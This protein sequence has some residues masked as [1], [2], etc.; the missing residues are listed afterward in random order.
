[1][2]DPNA[3]AA[4]AILAQRSAPMAAAAPGQ[5]EAPF[6]GE[7]P[8]ELQY[9]D[10][11]GSEQPEEG[12]DG[13]DPEAQEQAA[14][15]A[16]P[17]QA[18]N[19]PVPF[20][21]SPQL[22]P[23]EM[24]ANPA[25]ADGSISNPMQLEHSLLV[26]RDKELAGNAQG[27]RE[28]K[29]Y[30]GHLEQEAAQE[31]KAAQPFMDA[32]NLQQQA[33]IV[34]L[35]TAHKAIQEQMEAKMR[36]FQSIQDEMAVMAAQKPKD[37][38]GEAGVNSVMGR[39]AIFLGGAG[40]AG[41]GNAPNENLQRIQNMADRN[42]AAQK[43]RFEMLAK[44]G[45]GDQTMYGM[46]TQKLQNTDA[47]EATMR[48]AYLTLAENQVKASMNSFAGPRAKLEGEKF[49]LESAN[50]RRENDAMAQQR[51]QQGA[52]TSIQ[53]AQE[54]EKQRLIR[55]QHAIEMAKKEQRYQEEH[56]LGG[57]I[58]TFSS[59]DHGRLS[60]TIGAY[61]G[62]IAMLGDMNQTL[63][64]APTMEKIRAFGI[65]NAE[66][67][68]DARSAWEMGARLEGPETK[69]ATTA[70]LNKLDAL[71]YQLQHVTTRTDA[72]SLLRKIEDT[73]ATLTKAA[74]VKMKTAAPNIKFDK[75]DK[76]WGRFDPATF[77]PNYVRQTEKE[78]GTAKGQEEL[79]DYR[80]ID[81]P[82]D[83]RENQAAFPK[84]P[85]GAMPMI[86]MGL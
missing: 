77:K 52:A 74:F 30:A 24:A 4:Q 25:P 40:T 67:F 69:Q 55:E 50:K 64:G 60:K 79:G 43:N 81:S 27:A 32:A 1:M 73:Q 18:A 57:V 41:L 2:V 66:A 33:S 61:R 53:M 15:Q 29:Q 39:I 45:Q 65:Q 78:M 11:L 47:V 80:S 82:M 49:L 76:I 5:P 13:Y 14:A 56:S 6:I 44:I 31:A 63:R 28:A 34:R 36:H 83:N 62:M 20:N 68:S 3:A 38:F 35:D 26:S 42:V 22:T 8:P 46:L 84:T 58:G 19:E 9:D 85:V 17:A 70:T 10:G 54:A 21:P 23:Q 37:L 48:N 86:G 59:T 71:F 7:L 72:L 75:K 12:E 16:M 51:Y